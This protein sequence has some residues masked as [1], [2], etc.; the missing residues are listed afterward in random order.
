MSKAVAFLARQPGKAVGKGIG[1]ANSV[2]LRWL[3]LQ[4]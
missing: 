3:S 1:N 4:S 2:G